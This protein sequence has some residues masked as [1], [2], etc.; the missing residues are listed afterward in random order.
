MLDAVRTLAR[1]AVTG[2]QQ[3][4]NRQVQKTDIRD[5]EKLCRLLENA[6][7]VDISS[8]YDGFDEH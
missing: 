8:I 4:Q 1:Q 6:V 5:R 7:R 3:K 2:R